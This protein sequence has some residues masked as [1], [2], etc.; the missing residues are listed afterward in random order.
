MK[1][2]DLPKDTSLKDVK[3]RTTT[4]VVGYWQGQW[5]KGV[6]LADELTNPRRKINPV[7]VEDLKEVLEWEVLEEEGV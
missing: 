4:G 6:W 5:K 7:F 1:I 3:V 2:K